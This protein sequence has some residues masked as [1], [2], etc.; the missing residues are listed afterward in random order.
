[1]EPFPKVSVAMLAYNQ[2]SFIA[3]AIESAL[4]QTADFDFEIVVGEDC[5][6]DGTREL[7]SELARRAP[8]R[9]RLL[10]HPRNLG[11]QANL[12]QTLA[13]C[14][15]RYIA[16]LE[17]DDYWTDRTKLRQQADLLDGRP[18]VA[19][20][21]HNA[22]MVSD[23]DS[24]PPSPRHAGGVPR[25]AT[26][27]SLMNGN[28]LVTCTVMF[29]AGLIETFPEWFYQCRMGDWP[30]H[31]LNAGHGRIAY[32]AKTMAVYRIHAG[33]AWSAQSDISRFEGLIQTAEA[34]RGAIDARRQNRLSRTVLRWRAD[35]ADRLFSEGRLAEARRYAQTH[36][37]RSTG[38]RLMH[39]YQA[40]EEERAGRRA[41]ASLHLLRA[42][43]HA[44]SRCRIGARD[45]MLAAGRVN[46]PRLYRA[47]RA[48]W[49]RWR[50]SRPPAVSSAPQA[51]FY[52]E[53]CL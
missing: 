31:V 44:R 19:I 8:D 40:L 1:M 27:D 52:D 34:M 33:G 22:L 43:A 18:D 32:L 25:L 26:L 49:R 46:C 20:C 48:C 24:R 10:S 13:A 28:F 30:L 29:R 47:S 36:L 2:A 12:V 41:A 42:A 21:H 51:Y 11:M 16:L 15:G 23:D 3:Q 17:G 35:I 37:S 6:T 38:A 14:R 4:M 45:I 50:S 9:I 7:A 53:D 39:F 5:S